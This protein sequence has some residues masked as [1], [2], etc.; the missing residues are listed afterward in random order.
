MEK[1]YAPLYCT[2]VQYNKI[3]RLRGTVTYKFPHLQANHHRYN[4]SGLR[5]RVFPW[6]SAR[7]FSRGL[8]PHTSCCHNLNISSN[9]ISCAP[10]PIFPWVYQSL[11]HSVPSVLL[12]PAILKTSFLH[13]FR[14]RFPASLPGPELQDFHPLLCHQHLLPPTYLRRRSWT[15]I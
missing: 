6:E 11:L 2:K 10:S 13:L 14:C 4:W 1:K 15:S 9:A 8:E 12:F 7:K 5:A 3:H